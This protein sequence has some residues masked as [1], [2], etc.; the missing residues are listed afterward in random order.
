MY[1]NGNF[2]HKGWLDLDVF[3][4][5]LFEPKFCEV[6]INKKYKILSLEIY[7]VPNISEKEFLDI[8]V[9]KMGFV[10]LLNSMIILETGQN[11][12]IF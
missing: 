12:H 3:E 5:G 7:R 11:L 8:F 2:D 9:Q 10:N 4:E 1:V 6:A